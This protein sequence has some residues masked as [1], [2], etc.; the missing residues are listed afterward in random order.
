MSEAITST[1]TAD[2]SS[3]QTNRFR[4][5]LP[6]IVF[7]IEIAVILLGA[8]V[9]MIV[10]VTF[11]TGLLTAVV[12]GVFP[13]FNQTATMSV[14]GIVATILICIGASIFDE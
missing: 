6:D 3:K 10:A 13:N 11:I 8:L 9:A 14:C 5:S 4:V 1:D 12:L 7:G 2:Q